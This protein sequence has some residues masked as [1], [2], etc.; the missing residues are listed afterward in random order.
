M[1]NSRMNNQSQMNS[2]SQMMSNSRMPSQICNSQVPQMST[3]NSQ[4]GSKPESES[5]QWK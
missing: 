3:V 5:K 1:S 4:M 2:Q